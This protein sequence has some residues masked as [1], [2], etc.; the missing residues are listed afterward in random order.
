[1][2]GN[3]VDRRGFMMTSAGGLI[4]AL[5]V[6]SVQSVPGEYLLT[7][8]WASPG[9]GDGCP[10]CLARIAALKPGVSLRLY[11]DVTNRKRWG[12]SFTLKTTADEYLGMVYGRGEVLDNLMNAGLTLS[13]RARGEFRP[14]TMDFAVE[15]FFGGGSGMLRP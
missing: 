7:R 11:R 4:A 1:M 5:D 13:V 12:P 6:R 3:P 2:A 15:I 8:H 14:D 10:A 9:M